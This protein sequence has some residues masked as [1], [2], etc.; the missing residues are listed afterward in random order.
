MRTFVRAA[1]LAAALSVLQ[2]ANAQSVIFSNWE[3]GDPALAS[4]GFGSGIFLTGPRFVSQANEDLMLGSVVARMFVQCLYAP[5]CT[6]P[7][8]GTTMS[9]WL[10]VFAD[11]NGMPGALLS[12]SAPMTVSTNFPPDAYSFSFGSGTIIKSGQTYWLRGNTSSPTNLATTWIGNAH[13]IRGVARWTTAGVYEGYFTDS[14]QPTISVLSAVPEPSQWVFLAI[15]LPVL[16][17][18]ARVLKRDQ[19]A[20]T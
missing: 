14:L 8:P 9:A 4:G 19:E 16:F 20:G 10:D 1:V 3:P 6:T 18:R 12:S 17:R 7:P 11:N 15:A 5:F 2:V 13:N